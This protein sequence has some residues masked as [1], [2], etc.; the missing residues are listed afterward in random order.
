MFA[1]KEIGVT[2]FLTKTAEKED[3]DKTLGSQISFSN[4]G[5]HTCKM[6]YLAQKNE[7]FF[8][9][10]ITS[11]LANQYSYWGLYKHAPTTFGGKR[12]LLY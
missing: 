12:R 5:A 9:G 10:V 7:L 4:V 1:R 6:A 8:W 3:K 2:N 11:K